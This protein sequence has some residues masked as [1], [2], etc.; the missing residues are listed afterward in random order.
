M[1]PRHFFRYQLVAEACL[2]SKGG[3]GT[4]RLRATALAPIA[5]RLRGARYRSFVVVPMLLYVAALILIILVPTAGVELS[6]DESRRRRDRDVAI[7]WRR[8]VAA[9][10]RPRRGYSV[11]HA[12]FG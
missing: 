1:H 12:R 7:P 9:A 2:R 5:T 11:E 10:P 3:A 4:L 8:V 6:A